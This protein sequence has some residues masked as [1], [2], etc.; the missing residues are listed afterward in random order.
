MPYTAGAY[1]EN[2]K[3]AWEKKRRIKIMINPHVICRE[4]EEAAWAQ[5]HRILDQ[6][7]QVAVDNF[8][9]T[10]MGGDQFGAAIQKTI[11]RFWETCIWSAPLSRSSTGSLS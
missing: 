8:V 9:A 11:G 2:T 4:T 1:Q 3:S 10:F 7:D 5:Y 6:R